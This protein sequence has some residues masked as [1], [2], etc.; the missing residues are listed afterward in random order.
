MKKTYLIGV[1]EIHVRHYRVQA[2]NENEAKELVNN[3]DASVEDIGFEEYS[4][5]LDRDTWSVEEVTEQI[6]RASCRER[7]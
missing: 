5:T 6:G 4:H 7:V 3:L 2:S 1:R